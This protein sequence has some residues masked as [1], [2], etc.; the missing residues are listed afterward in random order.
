VPLGLFFI[1]RLCVVDDGDK[2]VPLV[3]DVKDHIAI[4]RVGI[5]ERVANFREIVPSNRLDDA[6]PRCYF[7]RGIWVVSHCF[8][9]VLKRNDIH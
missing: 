8:T 5:L 2:P 7:I 1:C 4:H 3:T 6:R 9:Q